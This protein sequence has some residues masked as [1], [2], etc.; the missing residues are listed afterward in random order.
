[1]EAGEKK[2][3]AI[4]EALHFES[5]RIDF[6]VVRRGEKIP[7][8]LKYRLTGSPA[9]AWKLREVPRGLARS[10]KSERRLVPGDGQKIDFE[11]RTEHYDGAVKEKFEILVAHEGAEVPYEF[12]LEGSVFTPLSVKPW[13]LTFPRDESAKV[14]VLKNNSKTDIQIV[15]VK[16]VGFVVGPLPQGLPPGAECR[17]TVQL[18][19]KRPEINR[20]DEITLQFAEPVDGVQSIVLPVIVNFVPPKPRQRPFWEQ[21]LPLSKAPR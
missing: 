2:R 1:V 5:S 7:V 16:Q 4:S 6:G 20:G 12:S 15:P 18:T 8:S 3:Q 11:F 21:P 9:M 17:L 14:I 19:L 13:P 10:S